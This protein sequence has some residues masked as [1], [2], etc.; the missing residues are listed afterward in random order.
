MHLGASAAV[1]SP[2]AGQWRYPGCLQALAGRVAGLR[3]VTVPADA[4]A[5][6][7]TDQTVD[8]R[9]TT[10]AETVVS[11]I[12]AVFAI[13]ITGSEG[14]LLRAET[15]LQSAREACDSA[16]EMGDGSIFVAGAENAEKRQFE[17][18][19]AY[20]EQ[21]LERG[22]LVV[23]GQHVESLGDRAV[24]PA[25]QVAIGATDRNGKLI[26][27]HLFAPALARTAAAHEVDLWALR[28]VLGWMLEHEA[29]LEG[30]ALVIVPLSG[31]RCATRIS[32]V[33]S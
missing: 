10:G 4:G 32:P 27:P 23:T 6:A 7:D 3:A 2:C 12:G 1:P 29:E 18:L 25:L 17:Q 8:M 19:V 30:Y 14:G 33:C 13:G 20:A 21:A 15:L 28:A 5:P 26:P 24:R 22:C 31:R 16:R 9:T 11:R